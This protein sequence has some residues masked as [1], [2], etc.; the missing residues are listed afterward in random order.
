LIE[1]VQ[2]TLEVLQGKWKVHL[3]F[4]MARGIHRHGKLLDCLPGGSKK[5]LTETLR[6]L[7]RDGLVVRQIYAE[8]PVR[9]EYSLTTLGWTVTE[10]LVA[11]SEWSEAHAAEV[12][13][14]RRHYRSGSG[15]EGASEQPSAA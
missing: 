12:S 5:I 8:V 1:R 3:V 7:E 9:V 14:A 13:I 6:A 11:L 10:P 2:Q 15:P 4:C